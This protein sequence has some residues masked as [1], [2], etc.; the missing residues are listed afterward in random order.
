MTFDDADEKMTRDEIE[1]MLTNSEETLDADEIE[2]LQGIFSLDELMARE[3]MVP[4]TD[5]F[6]VDIQDDSQAIIQNILK[7]NYSRIPVYDGDKDT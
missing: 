7:Q 5:A 1:Y 4:R 3:V 6:M 2:M